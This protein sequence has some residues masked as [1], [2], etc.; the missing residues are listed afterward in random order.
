MEEKQGGGVIRGVDLA[1]AG[2]KGFAPRACC[3]G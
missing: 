3:A 2:K 1:R